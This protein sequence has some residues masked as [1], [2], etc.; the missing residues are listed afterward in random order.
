MGRFCKLIYAGIP[1]DFTPGLTLR[2]IS[3]HPDDVFCDIGISTGNTILYSKCYQLELASELES[4]LKD[5]DGLT[6]SMLQKLM[7][8]CLTVIIF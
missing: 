2:Y 1:Q 4:K 7:L 6:V 5:I 3:D 8:F